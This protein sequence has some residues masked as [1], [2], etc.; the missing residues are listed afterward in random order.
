MSTGLE[1]GSL[2]PP[3]SS[4][5]SDGREIS[6]EALRGAYVVLYF[7]PK[8]FTP[9]C[10]RES[11][12]FRD[13]YDEIQALDAQVI[14]VS[15]DDHVTQCDFAA[16]HSLKFPL[17]ADQG[18]AISRAYGVRRRLLPLARR[19]TFVIDP[20]GRIAA[21]FEHEFQINKHLDSVLEFLSRVARP[22]AGGAEA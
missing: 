13:N 5:A 6:L 2:A 20:E 19:V 11:L 16:K 18:G 15:L 14:G 8:A 3:F 21:R 10:T 22:N 4:R 12:R 17:I 1:V 9:G 7:Y